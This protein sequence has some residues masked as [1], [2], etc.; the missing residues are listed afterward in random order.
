M[1]S[2]LHKKYKTEIVPALKKQFAYDND[3]SVPKI[4]KVT[5][6]VGINSRNTDSG[7]LDKV[8]EDLA[9]ITGQKPIRTKAKKAISAFKVRENMVVGVKVT[10]RGQRM[11][12]FLDKLINIAIPRIR[13]FR[14]LSAGSV[15]GQ[16]NLNLGFKEHNV[17]PEIKAD[18]IDRLHGVEIS[19]STT[20]ENYDEGLEFFKLLGFPFQK[21]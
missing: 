1:E 20:A 11:Y 12:D 9:R 21:K 10:L 4:Q 16:G 19:V 18:D 7:Y 17:F 2:R 5:I 13:D 3:F 14:G 8:E 6:N 15:D